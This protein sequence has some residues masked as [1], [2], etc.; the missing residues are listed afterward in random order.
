MAGNKINTQK[1]II[2][3]TSMTNRLRKKV[4]KQ[5]T[6]NFLK[7]NGLNL[8]KEVKGWFGERVKT[9]RN[10]LEDGKTILLD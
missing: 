2:C 1:S 5:S 4:G 3:H 10:I 8:T 9:L 6:H 7:S